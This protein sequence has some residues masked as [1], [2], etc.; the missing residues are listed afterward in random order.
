MKKRGLREVRGRKNRSRP[1]PKWLLAGKDLDRLAKA[2]CLMVLSV[3]SGET[4]VTEAIRLA[5]VSRGTYYQLETRALNGMLRALLPGVKEEGESASPVRRIVELEAKVKTLERAR[6]RSERLLALTRKVVRGSGVTLRSRRTS[7]T[8]R[9]RSPSAASRRT[10][11]S[12]AASQP[13]LIGE[14]EP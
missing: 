3:L 6:R 13:G 10:E 8:R 1:T 9:G 12:K 11:L 14:A 4:P 5:G 7:L 2:R